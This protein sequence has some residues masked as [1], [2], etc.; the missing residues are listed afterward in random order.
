MDVNASRF[1][2]LVTESDWVN[3]SVI[4]QGTD[5]EPELE[6]DGVAGGLRLRAKLFAF[7]LPTATAVL[8]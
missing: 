7:R 8:T 6:W 4:S 5:N 3:R 1:H 2:V